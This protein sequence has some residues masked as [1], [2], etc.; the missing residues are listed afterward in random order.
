[1]V[2]TPDKYIPV[3][4][5]TRD[6]NQNRRQTEMKAHKYEVKCYEGGLEYAHGMG[7]D[8]LRIYV[9][10]KCVF[11]YRP[12]NKDSKLDFF[13]ELDGP[14]LEGDKLISGQLDKS[15]Y[16]RKTDAPKY[17]GQMELPDNLNDILEKLGAESK[18][19]ALAKDRFA[20][21]GNELVDI[22]ESQA[23]P[24]ATTENRSNQK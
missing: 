1:M 10:D 13:D 24:E 9:P 20:Q 5:I 3:T 4:H 17:I 18:A 6:I 16:L 11:G 19:L 15:K 23:Q 21:T 14:F 8:Q 12:G 7:R 2:I 22:L